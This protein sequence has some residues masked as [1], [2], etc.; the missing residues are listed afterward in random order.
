MLHMHNY[1]LYNFIFQ[2]LWYLY[3]FV[4]TDTQLVKTIHNKFS[5]ENEHHFQY[6]IFI[7]LR[8]RS[9]KCYEMGNF[10]Y[11][12]IQIIPLSTALV[13]MWTL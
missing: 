9:Y 13:A 11:C 3:L 8:K 4:I 7:L 5:F 6:F 12:E 2:I 1:M 10:L